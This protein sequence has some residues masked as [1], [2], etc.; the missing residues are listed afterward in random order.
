MGV[1][2]R[3]ASITSSILADATVAV[4]RTVVSMLRLLKANL[5]PLW[6]DMV[7]RTVWRLSPDASTRITWAETER[8]ARKQVMKSRNR[9]IF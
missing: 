6:A 5:Y 4:I 9:F 3:T 7:L 2:L 8:P 1:S